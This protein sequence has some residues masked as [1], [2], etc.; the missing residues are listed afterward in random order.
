[1]IFDNIFPLGFAGSRQWE[2]FSLACLLGIAL[3]AVYDIIR[4]LRRGLHLRN[5]TEQIIDFVYVMLFFFC[6]FVFSIAQTGDFRFFAFAAM[7]AGSA[8]E[9][10]T[11]ARLTLPLM[12]A[13][14][15]GISL[16]WS[17]TVGNVYEKIIQK[18]KLV[19]VENKSKF[20]ILKKTSKSS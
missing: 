4:A 13:L 14:F 6:Y 19:F 2:I 20:K 12:T 8:A 3:G 5:I 9:R 1:M 18:C 10:F 7:L 15:S 17:R 11:L 16:L